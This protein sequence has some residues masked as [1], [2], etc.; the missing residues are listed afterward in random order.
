[1]D[2]RQF[3]EIIT[4]LFPEKLL[5]EFAD[6]YGFIYE[7]NRS[8]QRIGYATNLS[9]EVI[10]DA[11]KSGVDLIV[12]HHDAWDF[13]HGLREACVGK[14]REYKI[15]SFYIHAPLDFVEFGTSTSLM[16]VIGVDVERYSIYDGGDLPGIGLCK[17]P[18]SFESLLQSMRTS[19]QE[20]VRGWKNHDQ[21]VK[22]VGILTGAG[23]TTDHLKW[24]LEQ[25]CDT[26]ITG[27]A[28]LYGIQYASF[29]GMNLIA[30]SHTFTEIFG[31]RT[32]AERIKELNSTVELVEIR[33]AHFELN[34][35]K[36]V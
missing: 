14:L 8:I 9:L 7:A 28:T 33:E 18:I 2:T 25:G 30:G 22:R 29:V 16:N 36:E 11:H 12:T 21:P 15:S 20:P 31:M 6:D 1:M 23:H 35:G 13:L 27:E 34:H 32:L 26:Y 19:L 10:E 3:K 17:P 24:A 5:Q 4:K